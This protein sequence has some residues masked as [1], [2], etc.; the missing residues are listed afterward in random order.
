M[1][2]VLEEND[3]IVNINDEGGVIKA[4]LVINNEFESMP[5]FD[6]LV[7]NWNGENIVQLNFKFGTS[8]F[9][10]EIFNNYAYQNGKI[11]PWAKPILNQLKSELLQEIKRIEECEFYEDTRKW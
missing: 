2:L 10:D 4:E 8:V 9:V 6:C 7:E 5:L 3:Y 1:E 11:L